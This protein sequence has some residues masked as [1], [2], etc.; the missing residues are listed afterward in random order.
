MKKKNLHHFRQ[1]DG[2]H[3]CGECSIRSILSMY[4]KHLKVRLNTTDGIGEDRIK[5]LLKE[6]GISTRAKYITWDKLKRRSIVYYPRLD[7]WV[8]LEKIDKK[9]NR[10]YVNDSDKDEGE[11][12]DKETFCNSWMLENTVGYVIE[13]RKQR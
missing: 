3:A 1:E 13:C 9:N 2:T 7:H 4:G 6:N 10:V 12:L 11:W 5:Q 8:V